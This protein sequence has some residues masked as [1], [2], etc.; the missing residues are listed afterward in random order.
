MSVRVRK[1][2]PQPLLAD[3]AGKGRRTPRRRTPTTSRWITWG[4]STIHGRGVYAQRVIPRETKIIEYLGERI[5]KAESERREVARVDREQR[6][7]D[8][9]VYIFDLNLRH[10]L[11]G[12]AEWNTAR[13]INHSCA[14]NCRSETVRGH[15]WIIAAR[16]I[17]AGEELTFD[18]GYRW[19]D[20]PNHPC[21]CGTARCV[22]FIV[23]KEQRWRLR[24]LFRGKSRAAREALRVT[25]Q[26]ARAE[27]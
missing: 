3:T 27:A 4:Q 22:G 25:A 26:L 16:E 7:E 12:S 11:D 17:A 19:R 5:T 1:T 23:A 2:S 15:I 8:G 10:D 13:L 14:P 20:W 21:R 6:G 18:Y 24:R 9:S